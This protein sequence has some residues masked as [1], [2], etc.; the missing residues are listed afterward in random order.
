MP[1]YSQFDPQQL[2]QLMS[3]G[4]TDEEL[5]AMSLPLPRKGSGTVTVEED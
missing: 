3:E 1:E 4:L 5:P 2:D